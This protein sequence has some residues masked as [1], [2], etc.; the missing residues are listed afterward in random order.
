V[1]MA[2]ERPARKRRVR[3]FRLKFGS[4]PP[5]TP[6]VRSRSL[7]LLPQ[8][9]ILLG[10]TFAIILAP[11]GS[12]VGSLSRIVC[13]LAVTG[14]AVLADRWA[15]LRPRATLAIAFGTTG[16]VLGC[17][18]G[19]PHAVEDG[20]SLRSAAGLC[21]LLVGII[22]L[23]LGLIAL[24]GTMPFRARLLALACVPLSALFVLTPL[25]T[26][27]AGVHPPPSTLG[28][29][30]PDDRGL[31]YD[32]VE[33][34]TNDG[35]VLRGWYVPSRNHAAVV[36]AH[37]SGTTR[38]GVLAHAVI[39]ARKG[40]GVLLFDARGHGES[41]GDAMELG[42]GRERDIAAAVTYLWSRKDVDKA[43]IGLFGLGRGG[44]AAL[45][46]AASDD[47]VSAVIAEAPGR[48]TPVDAVTLPL[49]PAGWVTGIK[50][51]INYAETAVLRQAIPPRSLQ[52]AIRNTAPRW[53]MLVGEQGSIDASRIY[54]QGS[55]TN[56]VVWELPDTPP[57]QGYDLH[58]APWEEEV[59]KFFDRTL[60]PRVVPR[61]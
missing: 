6:R 46:E 33:F 41:E 3:G 61:Q 36:L 45:T 37:D 10:T 26:S 49:S 42:W 4:R 5:R 17:G 50:E 28:T 19:V 52:G 9:F 59:T 23:I 24:L 14:W 21:A 32:D 7:P 56:V 51:M 58:A 12:M 18:I 38:S 8:G 47:R 35:L 13:T 20:L 54:Q 60:F 2:P 43:K 34:V 27:V 25:I 11:G 15:G 55:P 30:T 1:V 44:E 22:V 16:T 48:R 53:V 40:Y 39:L 29:A 31:A 57:T